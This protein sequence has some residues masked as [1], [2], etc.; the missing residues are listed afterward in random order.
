MKFFD[1]AGFVK[2]EFVQE[3]LP[4][5]KSIIKRTVDIALPSTIE[6]VLT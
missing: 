6:S 4:S 1:C 2:P 3:P 5:N